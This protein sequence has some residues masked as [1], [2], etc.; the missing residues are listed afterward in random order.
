MTNI[1][2]KKLA[3]ISDID[4]IEHCNVT[5]GPS[6]IITSHDMIPYEP[7]ENKDQLC[8]LLKHLTVKEKKLVD[9]EME[10]P[11]NYSYLYWFTYIGENMEYVCQAILKIKKEK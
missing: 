3:E 1:E 5:F 11:H 8:E 2:L 9:Y 6:T 10:H 7:H 4:I